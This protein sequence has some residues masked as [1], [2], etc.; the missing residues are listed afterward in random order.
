MSLFFFCFYVKI[1]KNGTIEVMKQMDK[2]QEG[3]KIAITFDDGPHPYY[4]EQLLDGLKER[5]VKATFFVTGEHAQLHPDIIERMNEE[6]HLIGNHT[7]SHLQLSKSNRQEYKEQLIKTN[8]II[9]EITGKEVLFVR[10]PY[11]TWDKT[12]EKDL[13]MFPVL[14]TVDPLDW[15]SDNVA[16]IK[17]KIMSEVGENDIIL[18]H[19]SYASTVT[20]A[21]Q[22]IDELQEQGY[23]FVTVDEILFD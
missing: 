21:L 2:I 19:D 14:W 7:Y 12:L 10:P 3:T 1:E 9:T 23:E 22:V 11:G 20:A 13:N 17:K 5:D 6:G 15:C 16:C 8:E 18:M 4:T